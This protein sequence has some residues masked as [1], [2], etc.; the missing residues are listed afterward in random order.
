MKKLATIFALISA[1]SLHAIDIPQTLHGDA[2][3][4]KSKQQAY[5]NASTNHFNPHGNVQ[6]SYHNT[7]ME[8]G[9]VSIYRGGG[10]YTETDRKYD[11]DYIKIN[12]EQ[13]TELKTEGPKEN[14]NESVEIP[15]DIEIPHKGITD[16]AKEMHVPNDLIPNIDTQEAPL[17]LPTIEG[18]NSKSIIENNY[19]DPIEKSIQVQSTLITEE[20]N[21][22]ED[23]LSNSINKLKNDE[24]SI[25]K[26]PNKY[27][28]S[29]PFG[30][31][32]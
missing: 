17:E 16:P 10:S 11:N 3:F 18:I 19:L 13:G 2:V 9:L 20:K 29:I 1:T 30:G 28:D 15:M 12:T 22:L 26:E 31:F 4:S 24:N 5:K 32:K 14:I 6:S 21:T 7:Q 8:D 23:R 27:K 25:K